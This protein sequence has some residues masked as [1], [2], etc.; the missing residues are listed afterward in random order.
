MAK[1]IST[2]YTDTPI[3]GV[4]KLDFPRGLLNFSTDFRVKSNDA[5]KQV[6]LTNIT[7]PIDRPE[8]IR[9]GWTEVPNIYSGTSVEPS[10]L[11][12]TKRGV[13]IL[14]QLTET[15]S[16]TDSADAEYRVDLPV[17]AHLVIKVPSSEHVS[18]EIV[19]TLIGRLLSSLFDQGAVSASRLEAILRGSLVPSEL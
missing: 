9:I 11:A 4:T 7:C 2:G 14:A 1:V 18:A 3:E 8:N 13:S 5:G 17:S 10:I 16:V 6:I 15:L 19:Q 12:P